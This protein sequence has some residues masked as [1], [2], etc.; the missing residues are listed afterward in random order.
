[1]EKVTNERAI[2]KQG[3]QGVSL[4]TK[5]TGAWGTQAASGCRG[6]KQGSLPPGRMQF[7]CYL[8][9]HTV[10]LYSL[11][12]QCATPSRN[13]TTY[14]LTTQPP[15]CPHLNFCYP[16]SPHPPRQKS[17]SC[18]IPLGSSSPSRY[19]VMYL[20]CLWGNLASPHFDIFLLSGQRCYV[21][22]SQSQ[23]LINGA[24]FSNSRE[25]FTSH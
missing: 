12:E 8:L 25:R 24:D 17:L 2:Q 14:Q 18:S 22:T 5:A 13:S 10:R 20:N 6:R 21:V 11:K 16:S 9:S 19:T 23:T 4:P 1:M 3:Q 15:V 7:R